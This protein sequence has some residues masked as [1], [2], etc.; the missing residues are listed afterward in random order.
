MSGKRKVDPLSIRF[1]IEIVASVVILGILLTAI[2]G[3]WIWI[4][5]GDPIVDGLLGKKKAEKPTPK[6]AETTEYTEPVETVPQ[7]TSP[8][9]LMDSFLYEHGLSE[10]DYPEFV[11]DAYFKC[12]ELYGDDFEQGDFYL[13]YPLKKD[14]S[15]YVDISDVDRSN[16]VPLFLQWDERWGYTEYGVSICGVGGCG[17]TSLSMVAYY[18]TG[19]PEYT[20]VYMM[21]LAK[22][23]YHVIPTGGTDWSLF[24]KGAVKLG[25][26]VEE[27]PAVERTVVRRLEAGIPVVVNVG[28]GTF[29]TGG[30]YMVLVGYEDGMF[31]INDPNSPAYSARLWSWN[32]FADQ[33]KNFWAISLP[34]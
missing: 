33:V 4:L 31:R 21:Q 30:H 22:D 8:Q 9:G 7:D 16:G 1:L 12:A 23:G 10:S 24:N 3:T 13:N 17:P 6:P 29:T 34:E 2:A 5:V 14:N 20:P 15:Y 11:R 25:F 28:P 18:L 32:E 26:K 19:N 27:L